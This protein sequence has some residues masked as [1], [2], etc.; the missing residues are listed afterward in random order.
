MLPAVWIYWIISLTLVTWTSAFIVRK[1]KEAGFAVLTAFYCIYLAASQI[2]ASRIIIFDL[3]FHRFT[4]PCAVFVYPF[5][6]QAIDMI[7]ETY[8]KKK[9]QLAILVAFLTQV[10]FVIF[11]LMVSTLKPAPF[12][13]FEV[14][15]RSLFGLSIRITLASWVSFLICQNIDTYVFAAL[16]KRYEKQV[17]LRSIV[18]DVLDLTLDSVIFVILAFAGVMPLV[19][20]IIGQIVSKNIIGFI[21]TPWFLWY[22]RM[23]GSGFEYEK[24]V[25]T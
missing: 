16:K 2:L 20:L 18:S 4:A 13:K 3:G 17:L 1:Y 25:P 14:A 19:P 24:T 22:K 11:I 10:L 7:N 12:F 5:I 8:G 6:A 23:I 21:D 15:W 9:A